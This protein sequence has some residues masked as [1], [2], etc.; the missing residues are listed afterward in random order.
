MVGELRNALQC[1]P[2]NF[3]C[4]LSFYPNQIHE[5]AL[6][7]FILYIDHCQF[8]ADAQMLRCLKRARCSDAVLLDFPMHVSPQIHPC[9]QSSGLAH[10]SLCVCVVAEL[11]IVHESITDCLNGHVIFLVQGNS[12]D[13][14]SDIQNSVCTSRSSRGANS[15]D[16]G[17]CCWTW[18]QWWATQWTTVIWSGLTFFLTKGDLCIGNVCLAD[19]RLATE[20]ATMLSLIA[21]GLS[22][23]NKVT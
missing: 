5:T 2:P 7:L 6:R 14:I 1:S 22:Q 20:V 16:C 13:Q 9:L 11:P 15:V 3:I 8:E 23:M 21:N 19:H 18:P 12:L 4:V 10:D 17:R